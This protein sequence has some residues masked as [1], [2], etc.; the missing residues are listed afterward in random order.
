MSF[1]PEIPGGEPPYPLAVSYSEARLRSQRFLGIRRRLEWV[2]RSLKKVGQN[3]VAVSMTETKGIIIARVRHVND[4]TGQKTSCLLAFSSA[5]I[6]HIEVTAVILQFCSAW[7]LTLFHLR[8]KVI[9]RLI[10]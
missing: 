7:H 9:H 4:K 6:A 3:F 2:P 10:H 1:D 5:V 8:F